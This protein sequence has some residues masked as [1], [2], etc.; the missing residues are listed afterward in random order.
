MATKPHAELVAFSSPADDMD[1]AARG[2]VNYCRARK[3]DKEWS[4]P[5]GQAT[6]RALSQY[7]ARRG[8]LDTKAF[9]VTCYGRSFSSE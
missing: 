8:E 4:V 5:F 9:F 3:G 6:K 1:A 7:L 2:F